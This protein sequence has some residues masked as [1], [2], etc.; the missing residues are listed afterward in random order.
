MFHSVTLLASVLVL[1]PY[2]IACPVY[3]FNVVTATCILS[4]PF[5]TALPETRFAFAPCILVPVSVPSTV[6]VDSSVNVIE[7]SLV[8]DPL[9]I[10]SP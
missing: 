8:R 5:V 1:I 3:A 4:Y 7:P 10:N 2:S 9:L 6:T